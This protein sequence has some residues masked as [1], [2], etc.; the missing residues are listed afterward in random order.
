MQAMALH[1]WRQALLQMVH[2]KLGSSISGL[3]HTVA[4]RATPSAW[5]EMVSCLYGPS[6]LLTRLW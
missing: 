6:S 1:Q 3:S 4:M 5:T 2:L